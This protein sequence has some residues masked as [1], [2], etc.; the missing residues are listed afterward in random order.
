M[1][2]W[3]VVCIILIIMIGTA[4]LCR[5][6]VDPEDFSGEW[7]SSE[8]QSIYLFR[9]G[10]IIS[11]QGGVPLS[12]SESICGAY[13]YGKD[14]V[15]LFAGDIIGLKTERML[16]LVHHGDSS[17]LCENENGSGKIYFIRSKVKK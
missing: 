6:A 5:T 2:R 4:G 7:Y 13:S 14:K 3:T 12:D 9:D 1:R 10:L 15:F 17:F 8:D 16:Y 11:A